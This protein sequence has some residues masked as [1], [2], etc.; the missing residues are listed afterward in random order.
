MLH[1][2]RDQ[3]SS[4]SLYSYW[5][6]PRRPCGVWMVAQRDNRPPPRQEAPRGRRQGQGKTNRPP[7]GAGQNQ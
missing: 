1:R 7:A 5:A 6:V 3:V 4:Y 2:I